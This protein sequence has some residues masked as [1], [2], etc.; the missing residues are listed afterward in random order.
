MVNEIKKTEENVI[1]TLGDI[2]QKVTDMFADIKGNITDEMLK[3]CDEI[4]RREQVY[5]DIIFTGSFKKLFEQTR[6]N[7]TSDLEAKSEELTQLQGNLE[8]PPIA[9]HAHHVAN[10]ILDKT[11]EIV[12]FTKSVINEGTGY[13]N[14]TGIFTVPVGGLYQFSVHICVCK[15]KYAYIGLVLEGKV[16]AADMNHDKDQY[17]CSAFGAIVRV[18]SGEKVWVKSTWSSSNRQ[19]DQDSYR[20]NTFSGILVNN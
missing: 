2:K 3:R 18:K 14:S 20:M 19:L 6:T 13:D 16:I 17:T 15:G 11:D 10:L 1:S 5:F 8:R 9:F 7:L 12:I 4:E